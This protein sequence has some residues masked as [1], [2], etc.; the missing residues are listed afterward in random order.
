VNTVGGW[1]LSYRYWSVRSLGVALLLADQ[2]RANIADTTF[3]AEWVHLNGYH[4]EVA[5]TA[6]SSVLHEDMLT[7]PDGLPRVRALCARVAVFSF[8][9]D[10]ARHYSFLKL[11][12]HYNPAEHDFLMIR[13]RLLYF[14]RSKKRMGGSSARTSRQNCASGH[15][16]RTRRSREYYHRPT[17]A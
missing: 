7:G 11:H 17:R 16:R 2:Q 1:P 10:S 12:N 13:H 9:F 15:L 5:T 6:V 3:G 14:P 8:E 4:M